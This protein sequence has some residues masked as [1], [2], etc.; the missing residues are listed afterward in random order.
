MKKFAFFGILLLSLPPLSAATDT[1]VGYWQMEG[2]N[3]PVVVDSAPAGASVDDANWLGA[4]AYTPGV[5]GEAIDLTGSNYLSASHSVDTNKAGEDLSISVWLTISAW[6]TSWQALLAKGEGSV[7]RIA[8]SANS[9][10]NLSY[11][12]GTNDISGGSVND[13]QWHHV[14]AVSD[15][16]SQTRLYVDGSLVATGNA[17][18]LADGGLP[19]LIGANP[20]SASLRQWKGKIDDVG[21]F[22]DA[23]DDA[24]VA[25]LYAIAIDPTYQYDLGNFNQLL[26]HYRDGAGGGTLQLGSIS[27]TH[28]AGDPGDGRDFFAMNG[29]GSGLVATEAAILSFTA[30]PEFIASGANSTLDWI[31]VGFTDLTI[32]DG[33]NPPVNVTALPDLTVSPTVTTTYTLT[34]TGPVGNDTAQA[35]VFVNMPALVTLTASDLEIPSGGTT[36]LQ[37]TSSGATTLSIDQ[38]IGDVTAQT[39]AAG[40]GS[41]LETNIVTTTTYT[42]TATNSAGST[43]D[44]VTITTGNAPIINSFALVEPNPV[45]GEV[46]QL[47]WNVSNGC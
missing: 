35:T 27:W 33:V 30:S 47:T 19:L 38:G 39:D 45:P 18:N 34:G 29:D 41:I 17:P 15:H 4:A 16:G 42:I 37:W 9:G 14:V 43:Q 12:G 25:A 5:F 10:S 32:D 3:G 40:N 20:G 24:I 22:N 1:L 28:A 13:G 8:R 23:F 31:T 6:D 7:Y 11:A 46:V 2:I 44:S 26:R 21:L 36:T